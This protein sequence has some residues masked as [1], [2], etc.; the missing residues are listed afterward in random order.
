[1]LSHPAATE[2]CSGKWFFN[3]DGQG[4]YARK[5]VDGKTP[6]G[7]V[8]P[9]DAISQADAMISVA[10]CADQMKDDNECSQQ[11]IGVSHNNGH[12][13][14]AKKGG[15]TVGDRNIINVADDN[16]KN[17][18]MAGG[19]FFQF[20]PPGHGT[21]QLTFLKL[22]LLFDISVNGSRI[23]LRYLPF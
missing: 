8:T 11:F 4:L 3:S 21:C 12:C 17:Y 16:L 22:L 10:W 20:Q 2:M 1:M 6:T 13:W 14:C 19:H 5:P 7:G 15:C 23:S 9:G 18:I